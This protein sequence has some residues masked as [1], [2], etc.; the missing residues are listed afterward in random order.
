M[1]APTIPIPNG[2]LISWL[3]ARVAYHL[4]L[5]EEDLMASV[6][7]D[8]LVHQSV[9]QYIRSFLRALPRLR[10]VVMGLNRWDRTTFDP[11]KESET[12]VG[13]V[14]AQLFAGAMALIHLV[15]AARM[16]R[17][18]LR[19]HCS[20]CSMAME[21]CP[22]VGLA[23]AIIEREGGE[24]YSRAIDAAVAYQ[25][26]D[27]RPAYARALQLEDEGNLRGAEDEYRAIAL[28]PRPGPYCLLR[29]GSHAE[30]HQARHAYDKAAE[31]Y[32]GF[33]LAKRKLAETVRGPNPLMAAEHYSDAMSQNPELEYGEQN[34]A[35]RR[36]SVEIE[37]YCGFRIY[38]VPEARRHVAFP[39][40]LGSDDKT[41]QRRT[42]PFWN[43]FLGLALL[44][45]HKIRS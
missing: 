29:A 5:V 35:A 12:R 13:Q 39:V 3:D 7:A 4:S 33:A 6:P 31:L 37:L 45:L 41:M 17:R 30:G 26:G 16:M 43:Q 38:L 24:H 40:L 22:A 42:W 11:R 20:T 8:S 9:L 14:S 19:H 18:V 27:Y 2:L 21:D 15:T 28:L 36:G 34:W 44:R 25:P 10:S 23:N 1:P 32:P